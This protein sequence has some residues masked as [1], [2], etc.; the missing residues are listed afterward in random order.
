MNPKLCKNTK[1][2]LHK[3]SHFL[4]EDVGIYLRQEHMLKEKLNKHPC[5]FRESLL[6]GKAQMVK[7]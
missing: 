5:F 6:M 7:H 3:Q 1:Y 4:M 2:K